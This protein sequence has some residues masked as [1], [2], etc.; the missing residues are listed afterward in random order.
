LFFLDGFVGVE[1]FFGDQ[2]GV[3]ELF[4]VVVGGYHAVAGAGLDDVL[5]LGDFVFTD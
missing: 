5:D 1:G 3:E 2:F 4:E